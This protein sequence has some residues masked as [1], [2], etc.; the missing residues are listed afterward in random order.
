VRSLSW[1]VVAKLVS[2]GGT[3][4]GTI[5]LARILPV[6]DFGLI[7]MAQVYVGLLQQFIDAGFLEALIQRPAL[8]QGALAGSFW[9][10]LAG[11]F[12]GFAGSLLAQ[13]L[14][15]S[16]FG[17][18]GV[19][20]V[21]VVL[22]SILMFLPFRI[23]SQ[24]VLARG[25]RIEELSKREAVVNMLRLA[26]SVWLALHGAGVWS[27]VFPQ[28]VGEIAFSLWCYQRAGWRLTFEFSWRDLRPLVRY[29]FDMTLSRVVW[30]ASARVDQF[31]IGRLLGPTALGL[32]SLA[33][34]F[35]GALPQF[36][37]ATLL[38]VVF[39]VFA[40]L[41]DDSARLRK[42]FLDLARS[43]AYA[44]LPAFAGLILIAPDLFALLLNASWR[45]AVL[46]MQMLCP[47]AFAKTMEAQAGFLIN[48]RAGTRRNLVLNMLA[49]VAT[50]LGVTLGTMRG[51]LTEAAALLSLSSIPVT[52]LFVVAAM[53]EC[54]GR[55][56]QWLAA[57]RAPFGATLWMSA[58]VAGVG[59]VLP[60]D[61][62][63]LR[64]TS[65]TILGAAVYLV[66]TRALAREIL[67]QF[68]ARPQ[69]AGK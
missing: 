30:F 19:G 52:L 63:L 39:P 8:T 36:A 38:R 17:T 51:S 10:L 67:A 23:I 4:I 49:L 56:P 7:A 24:A 13:S 68:R 54:E 53:R 42:A 2:Q 27:L 9:I 25:L 59:A 43:T 14:L 12:A 50:V 26:A 15:E 66:S 62:H 34:Q 1:S 31:I 60:E 44:T 64:L 35:A 18:P 29:G 41:Q 46:P 11:G 20:R 47:L 6:S 55:L 5:I 61:K 48:A 57:L 33:W 37:S 45:N 40:R 3:L 28:I 65:M 22:S 58:C 16:I 32:Y 69:P 21:I